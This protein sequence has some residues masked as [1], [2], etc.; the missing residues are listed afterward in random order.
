MLEK[1][2]SVALVGSL[3]LFAVLIGAMFII[4]SG[5]GDSIGM[6]ELHLQIM[7]MAARIEC[8]DRRTRAASK[9]RVDLELIVERSHCT[10]ML[11]RHVGLQSCGDGMTR[12]ELV[13][14]LARVVRV[15][16]PLALRASKS[17]W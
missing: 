17:E 3:I 1:I 7:D 15:S 9:H 11:I 2:R 14:K 12:I 16:L 8:H 6:P 5:G 10:R 4:K 13:A